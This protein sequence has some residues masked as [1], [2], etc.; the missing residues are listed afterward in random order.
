MRKLWTIVLIALF[1][2]ALSTTAFAAQTFTDVPAKHW[3]YDAVAKL[4]KAGIIEGYGDGTF[5]GDKLMNR[6][7]FAIATV[8]AI[9]RFDKA[10]EAQKKLIDQ[11]AAEFA[12]EL[13]RMGAR[14]AKVEAKTN[15]WLLGG[16]SR[17]R[18]LSNS[19]KY[20][21]GQKLHG[22]DSTDFRIRLKFA[23]TINEKTSIE[24]RLTTNYSNKIGDT[25]TSFGST[26]Y[27]DIF[28][29]SHKDA[30]GFDKIRLG[31]TPLDFIGK[32]LLGKP[33]AVDGLT[34]YR[35]ITPNTKLTAFTGNIKSSAGTG[36]ANQIT[37][38]DLTFKVSDKFSLGTGYYWASIPGTGGLGA[39]ATMIA[40]SGNFRSSNGYDISVKWKIDNG[41]TLLGDFVGSKLNGATSNLPT[42]PRAWSV[43]LS[44]GTGPGATMAYY[45]TSYQLVNR[46]KVN[47]AA[48]AIIYRSAMAGALPSGAGGFDTTGVAYPGPVFSPYLRGTDNLTALYLVYQTVIDKNVILSFEWQ[49]FKVKDRALTPSL[50]G[51]RLD[52]TFMTKLDYYF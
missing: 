49:D 52:T 44:N 25:D 48:W 27:F 12:G 19:P 47:D 23:G 31:R 30:L 24:G 3:A 8:K 2:F 29:I 18:W 33:M 7:E 1:T 38:A 42:S 22:A 45:P 26:A 28:N 10:N 34:L 4:A 11:L 36:S 20:P 13:N 9:D 43:Q 6:Y 35:T 17:F 16:D 37:T 15:T 50:T 51:N 32:G 39:G 21:N 14:M 46:K 5:R 41:L 40:E